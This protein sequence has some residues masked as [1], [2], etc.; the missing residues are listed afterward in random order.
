[1]IVNRSAAIN[2]QADEIST[3]PGHEKNRS[4]M[5]IASDKVLVAARAPSKYE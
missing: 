1:M 2:Y 3:L 5:N 4:F